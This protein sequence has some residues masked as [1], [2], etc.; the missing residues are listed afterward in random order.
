MQGVGTDY[1]DSQKGSSSFL[2]LVG[3]LT[4]GIDEQDLAGVLA[5]HGHELAHEYLVG[6]PIVLYLEPQCQGISHLVLELIQF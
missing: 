4:Y 3:G 6:A 2:I 1:D 5:V